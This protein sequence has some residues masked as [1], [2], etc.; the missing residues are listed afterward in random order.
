MNDEKEF[1]GLNLRLARLARFLIRRRRE[2]LILQILVL[3][4]CVWA[5][6]GMR[7]HDDPNA[8]PPHYD[9]FV[10]LNQRIADKFGG[11][12]SVSIQFTVDDATNFTGENLGTIKDIT[13]SLYS[14]QGII[15]YAVRSIAALES[16]RFDFYGQ[17]TD[18]EQILITPLMPE[19]PQTQEDIARIEKG[20]TA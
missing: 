16:K 15:P 19:R 12:N 2:A 13:D 7:L 8:W 3:I 6:L 18:D 10:K 17:G 1:H 11:A 9:S 5:I 20:A 14:V 4:A